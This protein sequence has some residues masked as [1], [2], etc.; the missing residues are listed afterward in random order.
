M[1]G[2][3]FHWC[4]ID[5]TR[6]ST[7]GEDGLPLFHQVSDRSMVRGEIVGPSPL[8]MLGFCPA[9]ACTGFVHAVSSHL[10]LSCCVQKTISIII[11]CLWL[12]QMLYLSAFCFYHITSETHILKDLQPTFTNEPKHNN[13]YFSVCELPYP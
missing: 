10:Q 5:L 7:L 11:H 3:I 12:L 13:I 4:V 2:M 1:Y 9:W 6:C 8:S